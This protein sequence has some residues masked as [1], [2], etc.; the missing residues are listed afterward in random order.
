[1]KKIFS[2]EVIIGFVV[3]LSLAIL[4][5]GIDYLKGINI[6]KPANFYIVKYDN[7]TGLNVSAPVKINGFNIGLVREIRY[8]YDNNGKIVV[9]LSLNKNLKMPE[10][11]R[12]ELI[13]DMLGVS[14]IE[15]ELGKSQNVVPVGGEI[16][17][18]KSPGMLDNVNQ[19][20]MPN[21]AKILP[22]IDSILTHIDALVANPA[23]NTSIS[24]L[25]GITANLEQSTIQLNKIMAKSVP[26]T[27]ANV[28][29]VAGN[30]NN[31]TADLKE[32]SNTLK[33]MPL[34]STMRNVHETSKNLN[35]ITGQF[36]K[37]NSTVGLLL[38]DRGMYD[39]LYKTVSNVDSLLIDLKQHP[40]RYVNFK[41][42]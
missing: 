29:A 30:L 42:F 24:R 38:N 15:L 6:F 21:I 33:N 18:I 26:S 16:P 37:K 22:K 19:E 8:E 36:T 31:I 2:K 39:H 28:N 1:M 11:S 27:M 9:E 25:D 3:L 23:L 7:V 14:S 35:H 40:K 12:A 20:L 41:L 17:G 5:F 13:T 10:G 32:V 34:D 4:F